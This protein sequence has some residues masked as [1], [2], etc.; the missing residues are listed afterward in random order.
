MIHKYSWLYVK[1]D[2]GKIGWLYLGIDI[3]PYGDGIWSIEETMKIKNK[4]WTIRK[5]TGGLSVWKTLN[6]NDKPGFDGARILFRLVPTTD[7]PQL[8][9]TI[10]AI[11]EE[12]DTVGGLS[13]YWVKIKDENNRTG[14]IFGGYT[15]VERGGPKYRIPN[16]SISFEYWFP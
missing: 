9:V 12:K 15:S 11:T 5:M 2:D 10:L 16:V 14:W 4:K 13:D 1:T 6:V 7:N 3:D 8:D